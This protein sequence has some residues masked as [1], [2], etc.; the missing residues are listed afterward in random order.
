[1][2]FAPLLTI[3]VALTFASVGMAEAQTA[4][5]TTTTTISKPT[6]SKP[7]TAKVSKP[8]TKIVVTKRSPLDAGTVVKPGSKSYLD[9]ALPAEYNYPTYGA[10][11][12]SI[13]PGRYPLP[14]RFYLPGY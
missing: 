3:A 10:G 6:T 1:M 12:A 2:R 9:Y 11:Q 7:T 4:S 5:S 8:R 13:V 14:D